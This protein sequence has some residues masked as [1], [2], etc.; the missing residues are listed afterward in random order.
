MN[1]RLQRLKARL[2]SFERF[3]LCTEKETLFT[4]AYRDAD[5]QPQILRNALAVA[6]VLDNRTI[7][8][9]DDEL[10]VGNVASKPM[11]FELS[12]RSLTWPE[13]EI[14]SLRREGYEITSQDAAA[15]KEL[16]AYW[17]GKG[18]MSI[19]TELFDDQYLWPFEQSGVIVPPYKT[20]EPE[21]RGSA[22]GGGGWGLMIGDPTMPDY[23]KGVSLGLNAIRKEAE[24]ELRNTRLFSWDLIK[25]R[26]YLKSLILLIDANIRYAG[27]YAALAKMLASMEI[28]P[29]RKKELER[30]AETC[31]WV[32]A[33]SPRT[34][35]EAVQSF[36]FFYGYLAGGS[37][38]AGRFDQ[39][40]YPYFKKDKEAGRIT[41]EKA[42]ELLECLRI[43]D[44]QLNYT[45]GAAQREKWA[46]A[47]KWHNWTIGGVT[48][49]GEDAT[50][51]LT[52]LILHAAQDCRTPH[53]TITLRVHEGTPEKLM[54]KALEVV[55]TGIGMPAFVSDKSYIGF[56]QSNGVELETARNYA[57]AGC[58]DCNLP[59]KSRIS[60]FSMF[61]A[62]RVFDIFFHN[63]VNL[64]TGEQI[65]PRTGE[66]ESFTTFEDVMKGF[67]EQLAY[68]MAIFSE[69]NNIGIR[70]RGE[71]SP[72]AFYSSLW[73]DAIKEG[74]DIYNRTVPFENGGTMNAVG[75]IN[76]ADSLAAIKKLVFEEK[77]ITMGE[78][79]TAIDANWQGERNQ[80]IR[81]MC[82]AAPKFG[83]DDD[84]VDTIARELYQYWADTAGTFDTAYGGKHKP[85]AISI[86]AHWPGGSLT[87][88]SPDGRYAGQPL[89][90]GCMSPARG[91]DT[92]GPT[93]V[94]KSAA[95]INQTPYQS[96]LLNMKFHPSSLASTED[97]KKLSALIKTY[98]NM[99]GKHVQFNI[100]DRET[101]VEAQQHP[102]SHKDLVVRV[103]GYSAYF[104]QLGSIIQDEI[105]NRTTHQLN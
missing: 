44:M 47:A 79:K 35:Y 30:I 24:E 9:E 57:I 36:W 48:P 96:T 88:A 45:W 93:A 17:K 38:P 23:G 71:F 7:F 51:D 81:K 27:R 25:K 41:D 66:I 70:M 56:L 84:F 54:S 53:H 43:K 1:D 75:M 99:G 67:K 50:N 63:G 34:F 3:P 92:N 72:D 22:S 11:G 98:F 12:C 13:N 68:F 97:M 61:V 16:N 62:A 21:S 94:L 40:M 77:K 82:I 49:E 14:E 19:A 83:N 4:K 28:E 89:A 52:Y 100:V 37:T 73:D 31:E 80:E 5:N 76:V 95:K 46:G 55:K 29:V 85:S 65:G 86:T 104:V 90:D 15:L 87:G 59:G 101:L 32:P 91:N 39:Y 60:A 102:E 103:A 105:I 58:L 64:Q 20:R 10:I 2:D 18:I 33:N 78:L 42:L 69:H 6:N 74:K 26:F 8:I